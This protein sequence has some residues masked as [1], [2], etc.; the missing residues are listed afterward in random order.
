MLEIGPALN[1]INPKK[2]AGHERI[3]KIFIFSCLKVNYFKFPRSVI[4][5]SK[6]HS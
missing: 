3:Y 5:K 1:Q 4:Y 6:Y 2:Y